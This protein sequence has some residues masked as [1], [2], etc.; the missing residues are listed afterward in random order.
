MAKAKQDKKPMKTCADCVHESACKV[1]TNG[2]ALADEN[3]AKCPEF[4]TVRDT[5]SYLIGKMEGAESVV[6]PKEVVVK[7]ELGA[8]SAAKAADSLKNL[9]DSLKE[10]AHVFENAEH[11]VCCGEIVPE[12]RQV[13]PGCETGGDSDG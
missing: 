1:W 7:L 8:N 12:G 4:E 13:C 9:A 10:A 2:R 3:A 11:C 6:F 5:A